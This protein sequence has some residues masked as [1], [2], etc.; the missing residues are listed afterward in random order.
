M[1]GGGER[2]ARNVILDTMAVLVDRCLGR[3]CRAGGAGKSQNSK[4]SSNMGAARSGE[5]AGGRRGL[6]RESRKTGKDGH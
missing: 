1:V 2:L 3:V 6:C 4:D 5:W